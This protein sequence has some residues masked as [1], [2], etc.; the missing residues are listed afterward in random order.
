MGADDANEGNEPGACLE[1]EW[2]LAEVDFTARGA[3][4]VHHCKHCPAVWMERSAADDPFR[5][6]LR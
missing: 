3:Q 5:V 4:M 6:K 2:D 1:H